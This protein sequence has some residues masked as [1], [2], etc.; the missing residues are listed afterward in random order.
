[1]NPITIRL[2]RRIATEMLAISHQ[3]T[4]L[5]I[6]MGM[7]LALAFCYEE[8]T[9]KS[10]ETTRMKPQELLQ[11]ALSLPRETNSKS[12]LTIIS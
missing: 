9:G 6:F 2:A 1:M 5:H 10:V 4:D 7:G 3:Q 8:M 12:K 11:W